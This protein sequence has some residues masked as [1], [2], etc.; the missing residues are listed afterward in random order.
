MGKVALAVSSLENLFHSWRDV[1]SHVLRTSW[2]HITSE[3]HDID[4]FPFQVLNGIQAELRNNTYRFSLKY[5]YT[6]RKSGGSRRGITVQSVRDRIVQRA[7]LNVLY[8]SN[9]VLKGHLGN[10]PVVLN[11]P[12]SFAGVPGRGAPEAIAS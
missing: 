6:K 9:S 11:R 3:A 8:T 10:I 2:P 4:A 1:R 12:R 5:G 7:I